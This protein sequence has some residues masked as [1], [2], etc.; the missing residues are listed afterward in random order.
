MRFDFVFDVEPGVF[1]RFPGLRLAVVVARGV[2]NAR[3]RPAVAEA[4]RAAWAGASAAA[5]HGNAQSH[6]R[7]A[8]WRERFRA[9]GVSGKEFPSSAEALLRRAM[10]GGEPFAI[11]PLVDGYNAVSLRH[12]VPA[13][14][15]D[16][17]D[18]ADGALALRLTR[19]GDA[20]TALDADA[21]LAVPPGEVAY[22]SGATILTRHFVWRQSRAGLV[23]P[24]TRDV[25]LL[26]EILGELGP[27]VADAVR[28]DFRA[29][30]ERDFGATVVAA[31]IVDAAAP[32]LGA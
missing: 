14:G 11:N 2:D 3:E 32:T 29:L 22:A 5:T 9:M 7:I 16:L 21:P 6:P 24:A 4:W 26:A 10:R 27:A 18:L 1:E 25:V 15:F 17:A 28:D 13:G 23:T 31:G 19:A 30:I 12:V 8:P 20:F